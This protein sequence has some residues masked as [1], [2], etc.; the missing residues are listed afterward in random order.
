MADG[1]A[2]VTGGPSGG[3]T[4][5]ATPPEPI[6]R[7]APGPDA[8]PTRISTSP[9]PEATWPPHPADGRGRVGPAVALGPE[10]GRPAVPP[11]RAP[12]PARHGECSPAGAEGT[13]WPQ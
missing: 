8:T 11:E 12:A 13:R 10:S 5:H 4:G 6:P 3:A 2:F 7:V 1:V 9:G